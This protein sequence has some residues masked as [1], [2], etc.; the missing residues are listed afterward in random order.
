MDIDTSKAGYVW[1]PVK[2]D[3]DVPYLEWQDEWKV[4]DFM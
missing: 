4:E 3:R 1:L 2:F